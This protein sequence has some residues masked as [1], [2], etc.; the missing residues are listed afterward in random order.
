MGLL[1][2]VFSIILPPLVFEV[3]L[4]FALVL[5]ARLGFSGMYLIRVLD[6]LFNCE[7][8]IFFS[9]LSLVFFSY[10]FCRCRVGFLLPGVQVSPFLGEY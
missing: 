7:L 1:G 2:S 5:L 8:K 4:Q 3:I 9:F 6:L 10:V